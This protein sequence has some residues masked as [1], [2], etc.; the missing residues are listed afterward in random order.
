MKNKIVASMLIFLSVVATTLGAVSLT[1]NTVL[2]D[3]SGGG[4][5]GG[6]G[7][8]SGGAGSSYE[9]LYSGSDGGYRIFLVPSDEFMDYSEHDNSDKEDDKELHFRKGGNY[10]KKDDW[11]SMATSN[12][13]YNSSDNL[14][15]NESYYNFVKPYALLGAYEITSG[16]NLSVYAYAKGSMYMTHYTKSINRQLMSSNTTSRSMTFNPIFSDNSTPLRINN[17]F[18]G[19]TNYTSGSGA[20]P[21]WG[22]RMFKFPDNLT[23]YEN[24]VQ[25][26]KN[27]MKKLGKNYYVSTYGEKHKE[28]D[29]IY[30]KIMS[31]P[32]NKLDII[33]EPLIVVHPP[34]STGVWDTVSVYSW[35]DVLMATKKKQGLGVSDINSEPYSAASYWYHQYK[36]FGSQVTPSYM[37]QFGIRSDFTL[38]KYNGSYIHA[39]DSKYRT[40]TN[41]KIFKSLVRQ[42]GNYTARTVDV[43]AFRQGFIH[44]TPYTSGGTTEKMGVSHNVV[45]IDKSDVMGTVNGSGSSKAPI[46]ANDIVVTYGGSTIASEV[47]TE[48][49]SL[50]RNVPA[51]NTLNTRQYLAVAGGGKADADAMKA[52]DTI[53]KLHTKS[54]KNPVTNKNMNLDASTFSGIVYSGMGTKYYN[55]YGVYALL[56][57]VRAD[58]TDYYNKAIADKGGI[59]WKGATDR[60]RSYCADWFYGE[61]S[62]VVPNTYGGFMYAGAAGMQKSE[63]DL[64][65]RTNEYDITLVSTAEINH[66]GL[67][68]G[69]RYPYNLLT[70]GGNASRGYMGEYIRGLN[71][72]FYKTVTRTTLTTS[73]TSS[74]NALGSEFKN[75]LKYA[76]SASD[77]TNDSTLYN[78]GLSAIFSYEIIRERNKKYGADFTPLK[79]DVNV[80]S[81]IN[82]NDSIKA[83]NYIGKRMIPSSSAST[84]MSSN[85]KKAFDYKR[86][87]L[88]N[89]WGLSAASSKI[90]AYKTK[91]NMSITP[92]KNSTETVTVAVLQRK[93]TVTSNLAF[94]RLEVMKNS[95]D[96][97]IGTYSLAQTNGGAYK[98][99]NVASHGLFKVDP[100]AGMGAVMSGSSKEKTYHYLVSWE[101]TQTPTNPAYDFAKSG[102]ESVAQAI[103]SAL[104]T[105]ANNNGGLGQG[106]SASVN[107]LKSFFKSEASGQISPVFFCCN[108]KSISQY[109]I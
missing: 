81:D 47:D 98:K 30:D 13:A 60:L 54:V 63:W 92:D 74:T 20:L 93:K 43:D 95:K 14:R 4:G 9:S 77:N 107:K 23:K 83:I 101:A 99:Y 57:R 78:R 37:I 42:N 1:S 106:T 28:I 32:N 34:S 12:P 103:G 100:Q 31:L 108:G 2:A 19:G 96:D 85:D 8:S 59:T 51:Y 26:I 50:K 53:G 86:N 52:F 21:I 70:V 58:G 44:Y 10:Y 55:S 22:D 38:D 97:Q 71:K 79:A 35:M 25:Q 40:T 105:Y 45:V 7:G 76:V 109:T 48:N 24:R 67:T 82:D 68:K 15:Q 49:N 84:T 80:G 29:K 46:D 18:S 64:A 72:N 73:N 62:G 16:S 66:T 41:C 33:I 94:A 36:D 87:F 90:D 3:G 11:L 56:S 39:Y 91:S 104:A 6:F 65:V 102:R 5:T 17:S 69:K 75:N 27:W 61:N 89:L 88:Y